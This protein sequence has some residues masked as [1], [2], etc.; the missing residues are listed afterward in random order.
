MLDT[1]RKHDSGGSGRG[2]GG[3]GAWENFMGDNS[4][5][6]LDCSGGDTGR[7]LPKLIDYML[8]MDTDS[9]V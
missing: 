2:T 5:F 4:V 8:E 1:D 6:H 7:H 3:N 9:Y